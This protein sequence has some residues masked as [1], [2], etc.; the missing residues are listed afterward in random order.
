MSRDLKETVRGMLQLWGGTDA[1]RIPAT[2]E[3]EVGMEARQWMED[4]LTAY[5]RALPI[6]ER[7]QDA[8]LRFDLPPEPDWAEIITRKSGAPAKNRKRD[9]FILEAMDLLL[10]TAPVP[11]LDN[12]GPP[13]QP[14]SERAAARA[15]S[16]VLGEGKT[17]M[18]CSE[19]AILRVWRDWQ[20]K[21]PPPHHRF[22]FRTP[23]HPVVLTTRKPH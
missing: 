9:R 13:H 15:I 22:V 10:N 23:P 8:P 2:P 21:A 20:K 4:C 5:M 7:E 1:L 18:K 14:P 11:D 3:E 12:P 19:S 17:P 16:E 6:D